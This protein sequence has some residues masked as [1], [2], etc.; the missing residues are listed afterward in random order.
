LPV[1]SLQTQDDADDEEPDD[2]DT[3]EPEED[4]I[5]LVPRGEVRMLNERRP[6][7]EIRP[8]EPTPL[9]ER[10]AQPEPRPMSPLRERPSVPAEPT[11]APPPAIGNQTVDDRLKNVR[12]DDLRMQMRQIYHEANRRF[13][14][15]ED[16]VDER[17]RQLYR[18]PVYELTMQ[19]AEELFE[20]IVSP[21]NPRN[22]S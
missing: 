9:R 18:K 5:R 6:P 17:S 10:P 14:Y 15:D 19:E 21:G 12:D 16:R 22:R 8:P 11:V 3:A 7:L 13:K 2:E 20:R 1:A 4:Q